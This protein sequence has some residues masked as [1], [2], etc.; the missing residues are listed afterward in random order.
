MRLK[1]SRRARVDAQA[2]EG[3]HP[4]RA[5]RARA[6][7][8]KEIAWVRLAGFTSG[9]GDDV[10]AAV[11]KELKAGA[12]GVVLDLRHNGGGLLN[13]AV[14]VSSVFLDDGRVVSTKGRARPERVYN[15]EGGAISDKIPV[16]VLVDEGSASA[17]EIVTGA[18]QDRKRA[19]VVGTRTFGKGVFQEIERLP[20]GGALDITV[21]EYFTALGPQPGRRRGAQGR[22]RHAGHPGHRRSEDEPRRGAAEGAGD[23]GRR[24]SVA[25]L[26]GVLEKHG[27]HYAVTP[28]FEPGNRVNVDKPQARRARRATS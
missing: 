25:P 26:V 19:K 27:K 18:L 28:F 17:S 9:S 13:E 6:L 7:D 10:K 16:V 8:G 20:N 21:G 12:K 2:R 5:V 22:R 1:L 15:A 3:R 4:D 23:G 24:V 11:E 14:T